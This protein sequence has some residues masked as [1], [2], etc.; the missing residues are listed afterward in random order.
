M[1]TPAATGEQGW[2]EQARGGDLAA[3]ERLV[4]AYQ[5]PIYNLT[6]RM[7]G[8]PMD[9]EDAVQETFLKAFSRLDTYD[10]R[11]KFSSWILTVASHH[12]ID[13]LMPF[14]FVAEPSALV[15]GLSLM[16]GALAT[17]LRALWRLLEVIGAA[18]RPVALGAA[19]V[20]LLV[21]LAGT[22]TGLYCISTRART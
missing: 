6:Y 9:A 4:E 12:C 2:I 16:G 8:N 7:L 20:A 3:F 11:R 15:S 1:H 17:T 14:L 10:A 19:G 22:V 13:R 5:R 21:L 18:C